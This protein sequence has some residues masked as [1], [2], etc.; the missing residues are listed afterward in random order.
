MSIRDLTQEEIKEVFDYREDK[1]YWK[2][3]P[4]YSRVDI[5][6]PAGYLRKDGYVQIR[7]KR[8][9]YQIHRFIYIYHNG[10]IPEDLEPDHINRVKNNNNI[11]N[12]CLK[13]HSENM[14]NSSMRSNNTSGF[15]GVSFDK[16]QNKW[17]AYISI[18][19]KRIHLG[20]FDDINDAISARKKA[21]KEYNFSENHGTQKS[22]I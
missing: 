3:R 6:K 21:N 16:R 15:N 18:N 13:T 4:R 7:Y 2:K 8:K 9:S 14:K 17:I 5:S 19:N 11:K 20:Y 12:L 22:T 1:F 10:A